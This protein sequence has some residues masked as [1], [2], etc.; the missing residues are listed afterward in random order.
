VSASAG[1]EQSLEVSQKPAQQT[2]K[3]LGAATVPLRVISPSRFVDP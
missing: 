2:Q 1:K 3:A